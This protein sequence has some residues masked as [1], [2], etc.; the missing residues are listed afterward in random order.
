[1]SVFISLSI[2]AAIYVNAFKDD[3][4]KEDIDKVNPFLIGSIAVFI[5]FGVLQSLAQL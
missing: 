3:F 4:K 1:M 2:V 5:I